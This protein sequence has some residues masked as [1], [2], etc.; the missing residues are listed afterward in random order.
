MLHA[1]N[2]LQTPSMFITRGVPQTVKRTAHLHF[3]TPV[4]RVAFRL[5]DEISAEIVATGRDVCSRNKSAAVGLRA[6]GV[7][8]RY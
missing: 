5:P 2:E 6:L 1:T 8:P 4:F 3:V 7:N